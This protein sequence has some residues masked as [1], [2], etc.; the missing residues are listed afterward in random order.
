MK[1]QKFKYQQ[2][3]EELLSIGCQMPVLHAPD[4]MDACRFASSEPNRPNHIPQYVS[5]P[6]RIKQE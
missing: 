1:Q 5:N 4:N 6:K 3:I 2:Q